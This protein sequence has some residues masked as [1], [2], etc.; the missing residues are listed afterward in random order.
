MTLRGHRSCDGVITQANLYGFAT[1]CSTSAFSSTL[2]Q[3]LSSQP[4]E[5]AAASIK[6][7]VRA[8]RL[9]SL[10]SLSASLIAEV[11]PQVLA[12]ALRSPRRA[13]RE[14]TGLQF[15]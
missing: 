5:P 3:A 9:S 2:A 1:D 6:H 10:T 11:V 7:F 15:A 13:C 8:W 4:G 14:S 12:S